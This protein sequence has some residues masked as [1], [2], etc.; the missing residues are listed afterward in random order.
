MGSIAAVLITTRNAHATS[1]D[2]QDAQASQF[3]LQASNLADVLIEARVVLTA[4]RVA[5]TSYAG[6][7]HVLDRRDG[8]EIQAL[9]PDRLGG[10]AVDTLRHGQGVLLALRLR[11]WG[12]HLRRLP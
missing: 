8:H 6:V 2:T 3:G 1:K 5:F 12:V 11:D 4:D 9:P 10:L 7:L